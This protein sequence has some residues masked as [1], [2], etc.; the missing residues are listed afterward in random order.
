M[1]LNGF[2]INCCCYVFIIQFLRFVYHKSMTEQFKCNRFPKRDQMKIM[3][4]EDFK[5]WQFK[6]KYLK[7]HSMHQQMGFI[8]Y[9]IHSNLGVKRKYSN[10][11]KLMLSRQR[12]LKLNLFADGEESH[13]EGENNVVEKANI[14]FWA[15]KLP[16]NN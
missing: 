6:K 2:W 15:W 14:A 11:C 12:L 8:R 3:M 9:L 5:K 13:T 10:F 7:Y 1:W 4:A 16:R